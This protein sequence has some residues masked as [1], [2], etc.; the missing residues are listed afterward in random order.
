MLD[1]VA[2]AASELLPSVTTADAPDIVLKKLLAGVARAKG[3]F[4]ATIVAQMLRGSRAK[5]VKQFNLDQL[6]THGILSDLQQ[7]DIVELL[8]VVTRHGMLVRNEYGAL[9]LTELGGEVMRDQADPPEAF[10][11]QWSLIVTPRASRGAAGSGRSG[12]STRRRTTTGSTIDETLALL[13]EGNDYRE[14]ASLRDIQPRTILNHMMQLA[15]RGESLDVAGEVRDD[16]LVALRTHAADW[17][18][19]NALRPLKDALPM[20]CSYD[21]LKLALVALLMERS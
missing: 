15:E 4:G 9:G 7:Q 8:D 14:V 3:R 17:T 16:V 12:S 11:Q 6:S 18:T 13:Q 20:N 21:E 1:Y 10:S 2:D 19:D 5:K